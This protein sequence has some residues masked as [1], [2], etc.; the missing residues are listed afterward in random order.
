MTKQELQDLQGKIRNP[1]NGLEQ[2][3]DDMRF[4]LLEKIAEDIEIAEL[5][6]ESEHD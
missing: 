2:L 5:M 4:Y 1:V 3:I 6:G